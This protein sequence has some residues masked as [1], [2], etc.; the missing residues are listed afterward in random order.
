MRN[1]SHLD[2]PSFGQILFSKEKMSVFL[3]NQSEIDEYLLDT[4]GKD[5][6]LPETVEEYEKIMRNEGFKPMSKQQYENY[7]KVIKKYVPIIYLDAALYDFTTKDFVRDM[8][9]QLV[10]HSKPN[11]LL[12]WLQQQMELKR[13]GV[14]NNEL[15][16]RGIN[17]KK[18]GVKSMY[19]EVDE[20]EHHAYLTVYEDVNGQRLFQD[21]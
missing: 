14:K 17:A 2:V 13:R 11:T 20:G 12:C 15:E 4:Y 9:G 5:Y 7:S 6:K 19:R 1:W 18:L 21:V 16:R 10:T 3:A 8:N